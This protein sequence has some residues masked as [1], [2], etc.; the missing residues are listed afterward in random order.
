MYISSWHSALNTVGTYY[1]FILTL[2][3]WHGPNC[4]LKEDSLCS[5]SQYWSA[6]HPGTSASFQHPEIEFCPPGHQG[7][8]S[9]LFSTIHT[10]PRLWEFLRIFLQEQ[11]KAALAELTPLF[12]TPHSS[13]S[14]FID[15][16]VLLHFSVDGSLHYKWRWFNLYLRGRESLGFLNIFFFLPE[17]LRQGK[18]SWKVEC[19]VMGSR[20]CWEAGMLPGWVGMLRAVWGLEKQ[21]CCLWFLK[22][23]LF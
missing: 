17:I 1:S 21:P 20:H 7:S 8:L 13:L 15:K 11:D 9:I 16:R 3:L 5:H 19:I 14:S 10:A 12:P 6:S 4:M 18:E 2:P 22:K 23:K